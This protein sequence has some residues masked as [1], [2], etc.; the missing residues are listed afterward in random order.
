[1]GNER[2]DTGLNRLSI[3]GKPP[4]WAHAVAVKKLH[5]WKKRK[6]YVYPYPYYDW[7]YGP[8]PYWPYWGDWDEE[9]E[10]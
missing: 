10:D 4:T 9:E 5:L 8:G 1:M 3:S 7:Y 6:T 2:H